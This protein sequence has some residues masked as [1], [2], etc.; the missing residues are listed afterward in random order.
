[1]YW[2][3]IVTNPGIIIVAN[4][5]ENKNFFP[6]KEILAN[7]Y[8]I[9]ELDTTFPRTTKKVINKVFFMY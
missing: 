8:A 1:M 2:G 7:P 6:G 4:T 5:K 9:N 3:I